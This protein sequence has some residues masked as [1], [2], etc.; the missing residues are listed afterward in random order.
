MSPGENTAL[1]LRFMYKIF[2][3]S[4]IVRLKQLKEG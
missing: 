3:L 2:E 1:A 4:L